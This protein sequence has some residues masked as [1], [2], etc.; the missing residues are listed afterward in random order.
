MTGAVMLT[1]ED[2]V[3]L[4]GRQRDPEKRARMKVLA[5]GAMYS[6]DRSAKIF[7]PCWLIRDLEGAEKFLPPQ[8]EHG[9]VPAPVD[10]PSQSRRA[11]RRRR[12]RP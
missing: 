4:V 11:R 3:V 12:G 9:Y 7:M 8:P 6:S 1:Q 5:Y 2:Y 10:P